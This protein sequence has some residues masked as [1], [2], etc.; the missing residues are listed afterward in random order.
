MN[1]RIFWIAAV[2]VTAFVLS[3]NASA[4]TG[5][6]RQGG[7]AFAGGGFG[8]AASLA[9]LL[10][11]EEVV[12]ILGLT[13]TQ[14][15]E[16]A[17]ATRA[18]GRGQG[19]QGQGQGG[20]GQAGGR[21][22]L[23]PAELRTRSN[24]QWANIGKVLN[25]EQLTKFKEI[26]FQA[27]NGLNSMQLDARLLGAVNLTDD[28]VKKIDEIADKRTEENRAAMQGRQGGQGG[29]AGFTPE[30]R[31]AMMERNGKYADQIKAVL[32]EEQKKKADD[33]TA[34]SAALREKLGLPAPGQRGQG[35][36][37]QGQGGQGTGRTRGGNNN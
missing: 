37:G 22:T 10:R 18:G 21:Q 36:R 1:K 2:T 23:T 28:Q 25:A 8:G 9:Q 24:E 15:T 4:Q 3:L 19:G 6:A 5:G 27:A 20:Q 26:Y 33:L 7:P 32:T 13:E 30:E 14:T 11:N 16:L 35:Q 31:T 29:G 12:K 34:G 17:T